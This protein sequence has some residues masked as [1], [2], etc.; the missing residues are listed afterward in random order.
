MVR[1]VVIKTLSKLVETGVQG[2]GVFRKC[3]DEAN[4]PTLKSYFD[5]CANQCLEQVMRWTDELAVLGIEVKF[6]TSNG[7]S[8]VPQGSFDADHF[9]SGATDSIEA[10]ASAPSAPTYH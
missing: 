4:N 6:V 7:E 9:D 2:E 5:S 10:G 8:V 3:A 1:D